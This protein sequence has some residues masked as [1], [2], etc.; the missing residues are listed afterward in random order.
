MG[1]YLR[2]A[3]A[4]VEGEQPRSPQF[5][6]KSSTRSVFLPEHLPMVPS[7]RWRLEHEMAE[8]RRSYKRC[9]RFIEL[10][11][12]SIKCVHQLHLDSSL[13]GLYEGDTSAGID[14]ASG[15]VLAPMAGRI[16]E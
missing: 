13:H 10:V 5:A 9:I 3:V 8:G 4:D 14:A 7:R 12:R 2:F 16:A 6:G 15:D 11:P 1:L